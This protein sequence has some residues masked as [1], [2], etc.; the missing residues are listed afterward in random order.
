MKNPCLIRVRP[1][2]SVA[3]LKIIKLAQVIYTLLFRDK[4]F[5]CSVSSDNLCT[6]DLCKGKRVN[7]K[8]TAGNATEVGC[9][10]SGFFHHEDVINMF[11]N[12]NSK[13]LLY[14]MES[15]PIRW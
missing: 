13:L 8:N 9:L 3:K 14:Y 7:T 11:L 4:I 5:G 6:F 1:I 15:Y 12:D 10:L 2:V